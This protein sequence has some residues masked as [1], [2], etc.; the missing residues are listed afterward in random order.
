MANRMRGGLTSW[1]SAEEGERFNYSTPPTK[2]CNSCFGRE[3]WAWVGAEEYGWTCG[4]CIRPLHT[5]IVRLT[6]LAR[7]ERPKPRWW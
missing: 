1:E 4:T 7:V 3:F 5:E 6:I 2:P